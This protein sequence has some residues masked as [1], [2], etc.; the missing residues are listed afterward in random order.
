MTID[1]RRAAKKGTTQRGG[2]LSLVPR[3]RKARKRWQQK[4]SRKRW[5]SS[6]DQSR[7]EQPPP[8]HGYTMPIAG[9]DVSGHIA[10]T[11]PLRFRPPLIDRATNR[12]GFEY[13]WKLLQYALILTTQLPS[14]P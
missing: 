5:L 1:L 13:N 12:K 6:A 2:T 9:T 3:R 11:S 4:A 10:M 7:I 8:S 14:Q